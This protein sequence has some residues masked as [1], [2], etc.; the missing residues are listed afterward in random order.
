[1]KELSLKEIQ[2]ESLRILKDVHSFCEKNGIRYSLAYG[3]LIGAV[4]HKGFIPWD[5]D[6]DIVM[7]RPDFDKFCREFVSQDD[8]V[9]YSPE[10]EENFLM[11]ARVCSDS[12]TKA[13]SK[14]PW[15]SVETG[16]WIDVF[17]LDGLNPSRGT[18]IKELGYLRSL[19]RKEMRL[20]TGKY[21]KLNRNLSCKEVLACLLKKVLYFPF[22]LK[23]VKAKHND[24]LR[25][26]DYESANYC[27]QLCVMDYPEKEYNLKNW[28]SSYRKVPFEDVDLFISENYHDI[29]SQYYGNYM[30]LP[31][32]NQR[33]PP[34][35]YIKFFWR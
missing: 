15:S 11:F 18:F 16:L 3:T 7:P 12:R 4:R 8:N 10:S 6:V 21:L 27:G 33:V 24:F 1:M 35:S 20:R 23:R 2:R 19:G 5:D 29:L 32:E 26:F 14:R 30:S 13:V 17:P 9:L 28:F 34:Q 25:R 31:P 22:C